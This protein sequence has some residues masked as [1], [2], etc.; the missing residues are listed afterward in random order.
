MQLS[1]EGEVLAVLPAK[2]GRSCRL[3]LR[4]SAIRNG[5]VVVPVAVAAG[6]KVGESFTCPVRSMTDGTLMYAG[7]WPAVVAPDAAA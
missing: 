1:V 5:V 3:V 6:A 7:E 4:D 2:S